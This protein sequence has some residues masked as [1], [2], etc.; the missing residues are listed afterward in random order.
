MSRP[1]WASRASA[2]PV[3]GPLRRRGWDGL[4]TV[5][6]GR[7]RARPGPRS[8]SR[9]RCWPAATASGSGGTGSLRSTGVPA[10][11]VS[12]ILT[13]HGRPPLAVLDPVTGMVIRASRSTAIRYERA[14]A[15][16]SG[17][18][19]RQEAR[20]DPRRRR[21]ARP[22]PRGPARGQARIGYDYVHAAIDD[23]TRLG[24]R[25]D[26]ARREGPHLRRVSGSAPR[27]G[28]P[29]T[30][31]LHRQVMSDNA[32]NYLLS[33]ASPTPWPP[34]AASTSHPTALPL[35]ERQSRTI[36]PHPGH[37]M[38]LPPALHQ[39]RATNRRPGPLAGDLQH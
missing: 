13:R 34:P 25:R 20:Q 39:Q 26:P 31:S 9:R 10:R 6:A 24:L 32:K 30:A 3:G 17:P 29:P 5:P 38:G 16:G 18:H 22:R 37:R 11:T 23:Y 36:Q 8:R 28:S 15:R 35:A 19:R 14:S 21:L 4:Q 12:R 1:R 7:V 2:A 27:P 33:L